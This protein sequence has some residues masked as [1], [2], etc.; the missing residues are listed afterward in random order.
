MLVAF[1]FA[2]CSDDS[3][4][5]I[6]DTDLAVSPTGIAFDSV[7]TATVAVE[8]TGA[9]TASLSDTTWCAL[10][11]T[12]GVGPGEILVTLKP[13]ESMDPKR[14]EL[15]I[16][17]TDAPEVFKV[18]TLSLSRLNFYADPIRVEFGL[19][20]HSSD[21]VEVVCAGSWTAELVGGSW[22]TLDKTSGNGNDRLIITTQG[23]KTSWG[24]E[25]AQLT[26]TSVENP[27]LTTTVDVNQVE[28]FLHGSCITLNKATI[29]KGVDMVISGDAFVKADMGRGGQWQQRM[30]AARDAIFQFEPFKSLRE[31]INVYGVTAV[32]ATNVVNSVQQSNTFFGLYWQYESEMSNAMVIPSQ[33]QIYNFVYEHSPVKEDKGKQDDMVALIIWNVDRYGGVA[34]MTDGT[35][36]SG[37]GICCATCWSGERDISGEHYFSTVIAHEFLGHAFGKLADEYGTDGRISEEDKQAFINQKRTLGYNQNLEFTNNP[38]EFDNQYWAQLYKEGYPDVDIVQGGAYVLY[39]VWR[40]IENNMMRDQLQYPFFG[41]VNREILMRRIFRLAGMEDQYNL[42]VFKE[43]DKVNY[44]NQ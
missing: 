26:I 5:G 2:A 23:D 10:D 1:F 9:W 33:S 32:S 30:E 38:D 8:F 6:V 35:A 20:D 27:A 3:N 24:N 7:T 17:A 41:P 21:T 34:Q 25:T 40:S 28:E 39:G 22:C 29:G 4:D 15:T 18:V 14:A 36:N 11:K 37:S 43:Y 12:S 16:R 31:Y 19:G 13:R 42:E 44:S